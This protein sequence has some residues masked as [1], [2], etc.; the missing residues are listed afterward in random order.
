MQLIRGEVSHIELWAMLSPFVFSV[1]PAMAMIAAVAVLFETISW[2]RATFGNVVCF[3]LWLVLL[4][5]SDANMPAPQ[6]GVAPANDLWGIQIILSSMMNDTAAAFPGYQGSVAIGAISL[7]EPLRTFTW[8]GIHWTIGAILGRMLWLGAALAT[9]LLAALFFRRFDPTPHRPKLNQVAE[10]LE[11][12]YLENNPPAPTLVSVRL[13]PITLGQHA[14]YPVHILRTEF[15]L[16]FK[17][18]RWWWLIVAIGLNMAGLLLPT[19]AACQYLLP[20]AW[21]LPLG[22]WSTLGTREK[23]YNTDQ[24]VFSTPHP[25][26]RQFPLALLAGVTVSLIAGA[27]V[28]ANLIIIGDWTHLLAWGTGAFFI[29]TL[30]MALGVWSGSNKLFEVMYMLLWYAGPLN[31]IESL[32]FMGASSNLSLDRVLLYGLFT[33]LLLACAVIGRKHQIKG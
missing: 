2:L 22:L 25:L 18:V 29:P 32:D 13:T 7:Q 10:P 19:D 8:Q 3:I 5:V 33:L 30:A 15:R 16:L 28:A 21:I 9:G 14:F 4:I 20:V 12:P 17:G 23:R 26:R 27:G 1:L 6:A 24:L 31:R 11:A